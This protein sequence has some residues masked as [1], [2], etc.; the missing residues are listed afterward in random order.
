MFNLSCV[1]RELLQHNCLFDGEVY[2]PAGILTKSIT[3]HL[4]SL[5]AWHFVPGLGSLANHT[6]QRL[7]KATCQVYKGEVLQYQ[8]RKQT[9]L[10]SSVHICLLL[11]FISPSLPSLTS[12]K[13]L[14]GKRQ[15]AEAAEER[16][17][18]AED[19]RLAL[20]KKCGD[21]HTNHQDHHQDHEQRK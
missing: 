7:L 5:C 16:K 10:P 11:L 19:E 15:A 8:S 17:Y 9:T 4:P 21:P 20:H 18:A 13:L 6:S 3:F 2:W 12:S 14:P 1:W